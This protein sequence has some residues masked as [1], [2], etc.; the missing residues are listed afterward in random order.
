MADTSNIIRAYRAGETLPIRLDANKIIDA[1]KAL[2]YVKGISPAQLTDRIL[3]EGRGDA[4]VNGFDTANKAVSKLYSTLI[5]S[6]VSPQT[7]TT[8]AVITEKQGVASRL[9][10]PFDKA[11]NGTGRSQYATG[12]QYVDRSQAM[13]GASQDPRNSDLLDLVTRAQQGQLTPKEKLTKTLGDG[14]FND[15]VQQV[16]G[17]TSIDNNKDLND[18]LMWSM[19]QGT[20]STGS[21]DPLVKTVIDG[22]KKTATDPD[23]I[24]S[25]AGDKWKSPPTEGDLVNMLRY[26]TSQSMGVDIPY[27]GDTRTKELLDANPALSKVLDSMTQDI[28]GYLNKGTK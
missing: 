21:S 19:A 20:R 24:P 16:Y 10:I 13:Q 3:L 9:G 26:K 7:A 17:T 1:A 14:T 18:N 27:T 15:V 2:N 11:W 12:D 4:G 23:K 22:L 25:F 6:G 28:T 8:A 5:D